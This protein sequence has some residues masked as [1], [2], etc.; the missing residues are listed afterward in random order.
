MKLT[1]QLC[2]EILCAVLVYPQWISILPTGNSYFCVFV[3]HYDFQFVLPQ[4]LRHI[5]VMFLINN[6][7]L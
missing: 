4:V 1:A 6:L 7:P 5:S 3:M 2:V